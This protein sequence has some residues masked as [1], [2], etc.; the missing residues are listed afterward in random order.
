MVA[1]KT[2]FRMEFSKN[3][4]PVI[5][6]DLQER[7]GLDLSEYFVDGTLVRSKKGYL[8]GKTK[9]GKGSSIL[10]IADSA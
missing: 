8:V 5:T 10:A 1:F 9:R 6:K 4:F 2:V 3:S 7:G